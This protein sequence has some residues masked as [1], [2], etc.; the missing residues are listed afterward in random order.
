MEKMNLEDKKFENILA[1]EFKFKEEKVTFKELYQKLM[2][3]KT[4]LLL[5]IIHLYFHHLIY[6]L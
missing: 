6:I 3:E 5:Y 2:E 4:L 1:K